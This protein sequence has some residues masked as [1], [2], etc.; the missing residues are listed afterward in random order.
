MTAEG[1]PKTRGIPSSR[2]SA[3]ITKGKRQRFQCSADP[4]S[5][6]IA[7]FDL[8]PTGLTFTGWDTRA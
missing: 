6:W 7:F 1:A 5:S 3:A 2:N 4:E 8:L